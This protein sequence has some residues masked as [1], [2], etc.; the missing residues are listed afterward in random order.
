MMSVLPEERG[1]TAIAATLAVATVSGL[2]GTGLVGSSA[3]SAP[4]V[5]CLAK[6]DATNTGASG[7]RT[8][9]KVKALVKPKASYKTPHSQ[10]R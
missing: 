9:S 10:P 6:P 1:R 7:I 8:A 2:L 5:H 3:A 4:V